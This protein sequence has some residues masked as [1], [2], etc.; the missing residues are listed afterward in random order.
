MQT[1]TIKIFKENRGFG[2]VTAK[3]HSSEFFFHVRNTKTDGRYLRKGQLVRFDI[4]LTENGLAAV[5]VQ[6][7]HKA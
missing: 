2:F 5:N 1:G 6:P 7:C 4:T 3:D